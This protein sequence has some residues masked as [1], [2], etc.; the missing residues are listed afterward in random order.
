MNLERQPEGRVGNFPV[1][2][3]GAAKLPFA[4]AGFG[5]VI[6]AVP[7][8]PRRV[9]HATTARPNDLRVG[10][11]EG[12]FAPALLLQAVT[13]IEQRVVAPAVGDDEGGALSGRGHGEGGKEGRRD[14]SSHRFY[15]APPQQQRLGKR[16]TGNGI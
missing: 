7:F 6:K 16:S 1:V 8:F 5:A 2:G 9:F 4:A 12:E 13:G 11:D 14:V 10:S 3:E 15:R